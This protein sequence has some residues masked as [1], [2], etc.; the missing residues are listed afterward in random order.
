MQLPSSS[1]GLSFARRSHC[2]YPSLWQLQYDWLT[3]APLLPGLP[4]PLPC[5]WLGLGADDGSVGGAL[6]LVS[7]LPSPSLP[8][9]TKHRLR[10]TARGREGKAG[11]DTEI[12]ERW[13]V[14]KE[15]A[16][17]V[18]VGGPGWGRVLQ[19]EDPPLDILSFKV[20]GQVEDANLDGLLLLFKKN[21]LTKEKE[22]HVTSTKSLNCCSL[23]N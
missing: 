8:P 23:S 6:G 19:E 21:K 15:G 10:R 18:L 2:C 22:K 3:Q 1:A 12:L 13:Q 16:S 4:L 20:N 17:L 5:V 14:E 11:N 7:P 9:Q